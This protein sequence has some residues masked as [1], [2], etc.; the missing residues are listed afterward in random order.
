MKGSKT[1]STDYY[2]LNGHHYHKRMTPEEI[3]ELFTK[4]ERRI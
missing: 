4:S 1:F 2:G 3:R